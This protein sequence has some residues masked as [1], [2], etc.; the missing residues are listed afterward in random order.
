MATTAVTPPAS[1]PATAKQLH[2]GANFN[3]R[4]YLLDVLGDQLDA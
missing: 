4:N 2:D 3:H 1:A